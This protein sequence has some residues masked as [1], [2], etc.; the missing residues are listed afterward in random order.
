MAEIKRSFTAGKMNKDL[1]ERLVPNGEYRDA[2]NIQIRTTDGDAAGTV[3]NLQGNHVVNSVHETEFK[4]KTKCVGSIADETNNKAYYLFA[5][6]SAKFR[7]SDI[8]NSSTPIYF[9]DQ[10]VEQDINGNVTPIVVDVWTI[11]VKS[12]KIG[13]ANASNNKTVGLGAGETFIDLAQLA[14]E[15]SSTNYNALLSNN[16][17]SGGADFRY[18][19]GMTVK[20]F[21]ASGVNLIKEGTK[22]I[23]IDT[24]L[25]ENEIIY[26]NK[27][28]DQ[29][30]GVPAE[31][32]VAWAFEF[33]NRALGFNYNSIVTG[34][35]IIDEFLFY[36]TNTSEPKKINIR[37]CKAGT[38]NYITANNT[39]SQTKL[40][41]DTD[42]NVLQPITNFEPLVSGDLLEEHITVI[43]KAPLIAPTLSMSSSSRLGD[44]TFPITNQNFSLVTVG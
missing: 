5:S 32:I 17:T 42:S 33:P 31:N 2:L 34:I 29:A 13:I 36:T 21:N 24:S 41:I 30:V 35:N 40:F 27:Y 19:V 18:R 6:P 11:L 38:T 14:G 12:E 43:R 7:V 20:G 39:P 9:I 1:D 3:Q 26:L 23:G 16:T 22:I 44:T 25:S 37:R 15:N 10:I 28:Q 4:G 8:T